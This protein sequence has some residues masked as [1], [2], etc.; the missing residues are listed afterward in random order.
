MTVLGLLGEPLEHWRELK[1]QC[2]EQLSFLQ[3]AV[4]GQERSKRADDWLWNYSRK[5]VDQHRGAAYNVE[6]DPVAGLLELKVNGEP[7]APDLVVGFVR[8]IL[9]AGHESTTSAI[10]IC[11]HYLV[12]TPEDQQRLR[13]EPALIPAAVEEILRVRSPVLMMPRTVTRDVEVR[14]R[15]LRAGDNVMLVWASA[16]RDEAAFEQPER[17][18]FDRGPTRHMVFGHGIHSCL[19]AALARH[20]IRIVLEELLAA[21]ARIILDGPVEHEFWHRYGVRSLPCAVATP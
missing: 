6:S 19:G 3:D 8:L 9:A 4:N 7:L 20:E 21:T 18:V 2:E 12:T 5:I 10:S 15:Q 13:E 16:N 14:G 1:E 17:C 11:L